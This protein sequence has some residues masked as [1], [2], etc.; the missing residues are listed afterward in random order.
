M[1]T[2]RPKTGRVLSC[3]VPAHTFHSGHRH[4]GDTATGTPRPVHSLRCSA[5]APR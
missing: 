4:L 2:A 3:V 1:N 5:F